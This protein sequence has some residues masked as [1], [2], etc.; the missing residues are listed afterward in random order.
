VGQGLSDDK[1][2]KIP[3]IKRYEGSKAELKIN[4]E[5]IETIA[6]VSVDS[7]ATLSVG[8]AQ[9]SKEA[10]K[11]MSEDLGRTINDYF[12]RAMTELSKNPFE[13][14]LD[15]QYRVD[16]TEAREL[17]AQEPGRP[18]SYGEL[19]LLL[20]KVTYKPGWSFWVDEHF[21]YQIHL[22]LSVKTVDR[23]HR[24]PSEVHGMYILQEHDRLNPA[25]FF[26]FVR[27]CILTTETH[28]MREFFRVAGVL[29][30]D[31]HQTSVADGIPYVRDLEHQESRELS[32]WRHMQV[33]LS[34]V[35]KVGFKMASNTMEKTCRKKK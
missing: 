1:F 34:E 16:P 30:D 5:L 12:S 14:M 21:G 32:I 28:E 19:K 4:G 23:E 3:R 26:R 33:N 2:I 35:I 29:I 11:R 31:P 8:G 6:D 7:Q 15:R 13:A 18:L 24:Q 17:M 22:R 27:T 10:K 25:S 20:G 9:R